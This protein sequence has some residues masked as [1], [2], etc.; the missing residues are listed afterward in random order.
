[1]RNENI[2]ML[3]QMTKRFLDGEMEVFEYGLD[4]PYEVE[5]VFS[6]LVEH[7]R[8]LA[9]LIFDNLVEEGACLF[10]K[11]DEESFR[12]LIARKYKLIYDVYNGKRWS[13]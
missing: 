11:F 9:Y 3:L 12:D 10:D 4:F 5:Q 13:E 1:M 2:D 6:E 7:D 8:S